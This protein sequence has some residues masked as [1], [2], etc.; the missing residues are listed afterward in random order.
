[1]N[2]PPGRGKSDAE[3]FEFPASAVPVINIYFDLE[4]KDGEE[5]MVGYR[6]GTIEW[7]DSLADIELKV[8]AT[9]ICAVVQRAIELPPSPKRT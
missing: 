9:K 5:I 1:M 2:K 8:L 6:V 7:L 3:K 4:G